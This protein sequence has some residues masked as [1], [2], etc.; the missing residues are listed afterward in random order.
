LA[1]GDA[2]AEADADVP[3]NHA[4]QKSIHNAY[5]RYEPL[6]DQLLY[7]RVRSLELDI[8]RRREGVLAPPGEWFVFHA[9][10]P[11]MRRTSCAR[12][13][14]CLGQL[15][16]FHAAVPRHAPITLFIDLK[17]ELTG[18]HQAEDLDAAIARGL[19]RENIVT[20]ADLIAACP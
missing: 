12:L 9:D 10:K 7:H 16:A 20:P 15:A 13:S 11:L 6:L 4:V 3:Y 5:S 14:D 17:D 19:G 1:H 2:R 18:G 8:H